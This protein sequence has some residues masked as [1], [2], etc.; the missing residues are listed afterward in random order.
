MA[1]AKSNLGKI[2]IALTRVND[3]MT[4]DEMLKA[5]NTDYRVG[6]AYLCAVFPEDND[7]R[8]LAGERLF[9][10][11]PVGEIPANGSELPEHIHTEAGSSLATVATYPNHNREVLAVVGARYTVL[12]NG[13]VLEEAR[14]GGIHLG[15]SVV[16]VGRN[17]SGTV[18]GVEFEPRYE[19]VTTYDGRAKSFPRRLFAYSSHDRSKAH[20]YAMVISDPED[21]FVD[22]YEVKRKHTRYS[23]SE[24]V[25]EDLLQGLADASEQILQDIRV[26][27]QIKMTDAQLDR[28][29]S[30][31]CRPSKT[32]DRD[33]DDDEDVDSQPTENDES[34]EERKQRILSC[35]E[36]RRT[37][38][39]NS[40]WAL[41]EAW[42]DVRMCDR[43][44][45]EA[46]NLFDF[47]V[48][49]A[50]QT[51]ADFWKKRTTLVS[52]LISG[53]R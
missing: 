35:F 5:S 12:Q 23:L 45:A 41:Y 51:R 7:L 52:E 32:K 22:F 10:H 19:I 44:L 34:P 9:L 16:G 20:S 14:K 47:L 38:F 46:P 21:R 39:G 42:M 40:A 2:R 36:E 4:T 3:N 17:A 27:A 25:L 6:L 8:N 43:D 28:G 11:R 26:L 33:I 13:V 49:R 15:C 29:L 30:I 31:L 1:Y 24:S 48:G 37:E 53:S 18:F 50:R